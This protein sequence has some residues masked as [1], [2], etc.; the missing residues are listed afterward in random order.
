MKPDQKYNSL[1]EF[2]GEIDRMI[3]KVRQ[4]RSGKIDNYGNVVGVKECQ[5]GLVPFV[6]QDHYY[7][8]MDRVVKLEKYDNDFSKPTKRIYFYNPKEL[9]VVESVWYDR[10]DRLDNIHR[11]LYDGTSGLMIHRAQYTKEGKIFYAISS[12]YDE[13][14]PPNCTEEIW[15]DGASRV[16]KKRKYRFDK[17]AQLIEERHFIGSDKLE[18][19]NQFIYDEG[20]NLIERRWYNSKGVLMS[21][22][23]YTYDEYGEVRT[24][25]IYDGEGNLESWQDIIHDAAG[26]VLEERWYDKDNNIIKHIVNNMDY[27]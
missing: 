18:G 7:D 12:K 1:E 10:Y 26:N 5:P 22:F 24:T 2:L 8:E 27:A 16:V 4:F 11:Y 3:V 21:T 20:G 19:F 17:K 23:V 14:T 6:H 9:K 15:T 25:C 13:S